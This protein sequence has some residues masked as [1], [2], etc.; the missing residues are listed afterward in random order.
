MTHGTDEEIAAEALDRT[1]EAAEEIKDISYG[2][3]TA[4]EFEETIKKD[5]LTL[6]ASPSLKG[7]SIWGMALDT[8][9]GIV[10]TVDI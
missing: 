5:V 6:R 2:C 1:P 7:V 3:F 4:E 10:T 8:M 9:T